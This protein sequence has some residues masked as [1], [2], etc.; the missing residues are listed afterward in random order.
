MV[1]SMIVYLC[2]GLTFVYGEGELLRKFIHGWGSPMG[3]PHCVQLLSNAI[4]FIRTYSVCVC[5][6]PTHVSVRNTKQHTCCPHIN[7]LELIHS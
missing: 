3:W 2:V 5:F 1:L 6:G 7:Q 4:R